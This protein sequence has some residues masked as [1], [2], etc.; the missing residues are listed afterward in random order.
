MEGRDA[1]EAPIDGLLLSKKGGENKTARDFM[2]F[3]GSAEA[4]DAYAAVDASNIATAKGTD[5]SAFSPLN[6]KC[7]DTIADAKYI[8]QFFD[9]DALPAMANNVMIPALQSFI[10]DGRI[11]VK[12]LE[13]QA[14]TLYAAQ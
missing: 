10:K 12:N 7:A 13:A 6:K 2:A 11:D 4:Q 1:V 9:R 14:K 5:T 8:S 3:V